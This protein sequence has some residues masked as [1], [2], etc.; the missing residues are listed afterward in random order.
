MLKQFS[1]LLFLGLVSGC[2]ADSVSF[3]GTWNGSFTTL[4][5][6][7]S[8]SVSQDIN[9]LFPMQVSISGDQVYTVTAVDG[10][11]AIGGQGDGETVSFTASAPTFGKFHSTNTFRCSS[12]SAIVGFLTTG[13]SSANVSLTYSFVDCTDVSGARQQDC[14][15][16]YF[17]EAVK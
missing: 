2:G 7:C 11:T 8:F 13:D 17:A 10:S 16:T 15:A 9:P 6:Q 5:N 3:E 4:N 14:A 12:T 1:A